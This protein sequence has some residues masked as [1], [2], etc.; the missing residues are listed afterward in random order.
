M[1]SAK[2]F[3]SGDYQVVRLPKKYRLEGDRVF[4]KWVGNVLVLIPEQASWQTLFDSLSQ[5]SDDFMASREQA[6]QQRKV[7][8][9]VD[10]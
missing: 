3:Q 10:E 7:V 5:F 1:Q 8:N 6:A 9:W 2:I 4:I